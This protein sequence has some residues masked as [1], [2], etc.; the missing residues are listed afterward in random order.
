[1]LNYGFING[2]LVDD[3][4]VGKDG[5]YGFMTLAVQREYKNKEGQYTIFTQCLILVNFEKQ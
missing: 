1:M 3:V 2:R 4:K 5:K